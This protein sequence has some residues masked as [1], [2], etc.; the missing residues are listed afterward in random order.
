MIARDGYRR[1]DKNINIAMC[2]GG[3]CDG[4]Y[5]RVMR[6]THEMHTFMSAEGK[7][8]ARYKFDGDK[9]VPLEEWR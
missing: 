8:I 2:D 4:Q 1:M 5:V 6:D 7:I 3:P 9:W